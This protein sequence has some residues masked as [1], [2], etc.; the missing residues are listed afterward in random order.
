MTIE[1]IQKYM[2]CWA[3]R[4]YNEEIAYFHA[5]RNNAGMRRRIIVYLDKLKI[6]NRHMDG[7]SITNLPRIN[8]A[9]E[10]RGIVPKYTE[11]FNQWLDMNYIS[12]LTYIYKICENIPDTLSDELASGII[13]RGL[14]SFPSFFRELELAKQIESRIPGCII[15]TRDTEVDVSQHTDILLEYN[16]SLFR[17][18]SYQ[19]SGK[20]IQNTSKRFSGIRGQIPGGMHIMCPFS[21]TNPDNRQKYGWL[22][23]SESQC[24]TVVDMIMNDN[25][26]IDLYKE[27]D[28]HQNVLGSYLMQFRKIYKR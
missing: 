20:G 18:W 4:T 23:Y 8:A 13:A 14:R 2:R 15:Y 7:Y 6:T 25:V 16:N 12:P 3:Q 19:S 24:C 11:I 5:L 10:N 21:R 22:F 1:D 27:L 17:L 9:E 28:M 26:Q